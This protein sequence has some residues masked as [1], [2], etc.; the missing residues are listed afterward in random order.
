MGWSQDTDSLRNERI[1]QRVEAMVAPDPN[2]EAVLYRIPEVVRD[3]CAAAE[4]DVDCYPT[5]MLHVLRRI[6]PSFN[7][8]ANIVICNALIDHAREQD[9]PALEAEVRL[10]NYRYFQALGMYESALDHLQRASQLYQAIG[11]A[12]H[13]DQTRLYLFDNYRTFKSAEELELLSAELIER[14]T[15]RG[16]QRMLAGILQKSLEEADP[17]AA[18]GSV[19]RWSDQMR[20]VIESPDNP[21][22]DYFGPEAAILEV[23][24]RRREAQDDFAGAEELRREILAGWLAQPDWWRVADQQLKLAALNLQMARPDTARALVE[25]A[26]RVGTEHKMADIV[27]ASYDLL[28]RLERAR[29]NYR[30]ALHARERQLVAQQELDTRRGNFEAE[31]F[32]LRRQLI[33]ET[34]RRALET[35]LVGQQLRGTR[36]LT[37]SAMLLAGLFGLGFYLQR[38]SKRALATRNTKI[39]EQT[40]QLRAQTERMRE[41]DRAKTRF[42]T[43]AGHEL[44]TPLTLVL[45]PLDTLR[46][47]DSLTDEQRR[48]LDLAHRNGEHLNG[49]VDELLDISQLD[50]TTPPKVK[51]TPTRVVDFYRT[52]LERFVEAARRQ[53]IDYHLNVDLPEDWTGAVDR[54]RHERIL[55]NLVGNALKFTP[56]GGSVSVKV[57]STS[58]GL[59]LSVRDTGPGI[60]AADQP[61][62]FDRFHQGPNGTAAATGNGVG[63]SM[64]REYAELL[65]GGVEVESTVG[66]GS[67]FHVRLKVPDTPEEAVPVA[68]SRTFR[69][70]TR[71]VEPTVPVRIGQRP[72]ILL[73]EDNDD[74]RDYL[75]TL[76]SPR[77]EVD[78]APDGRAALDR[79]EVHPDGY[80]LVLSDVMMPRLDGY[81]LLERIKTSDALRHLPVVMLTA[82]TSETDRMRAL[83]IGVDDYLTKPFRS[84]GLLRT[85]ATLLEHREG[86][87]WGGSQQYDS[88]SISPEDQQWLERFEQFVRDHQSDHR[89]SVPFLAQEFTTSESTLL[90]QLKRLTGLTLGKY[91]QQIRLATARRM[92]EQDTHR[93]ATE[94]ARTVGY[95]DARAFSRAY[96]RRYGNLPSDIID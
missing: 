73:A 71:P 96:R 83:R 45:A 72:R 48:L 61:R 64:V 25:M 38:R 94:V 81:E 2:D 44:R 43:N 46:Q 84:E 21:V 78:A 51:T 4:A 27:A 62:I 7:L 37:V 8:L 11:D 18:A 90:R 24:A 67:V 22:A 23:E 58:D 53:E 13:Y 89:M 16:D 95:A 65:G 76:L 31:K 59:H 63:L 9:R 87:K 75:T 70:S 33:A 12:S 85:L 57:T 17:L 86:R 77:Y 19:Q 91:V 34:E 80:A 10:D 68:V 74:L 66:E 40:E 49:L 88:K 39:S 41:Q 5:A 29:G 32:F 60:A 47:T 92:L 28:T 15:A 3:A 35:E 79:L 30:A 55:Y 14:A 1:W 69:P 36:I 50:A 42:F 93:T 26:L 82:R 52:T 6:E 56:V 20:T 54:R